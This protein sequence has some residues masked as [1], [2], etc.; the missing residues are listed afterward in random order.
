MYCYPGTSCLATIS[1]SLRDKKPIAYRSARIILAIMGKLWAKLSRPFEARTF[2]GAVEV[3]MLFLA[4][5]A[6]TTQVSAYTLTIRELESA[7]FS[8]S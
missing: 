5:F 6:R 7:L 8:V 1:L 3:Q 2:G 4:E